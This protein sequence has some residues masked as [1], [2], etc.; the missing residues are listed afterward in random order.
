MDEIRAQGLKA[1][2]ERCRL[3][4]IRC[5]G[6]TNARGFPSKAQL[7]SWI[8]Q[9]V[10]GN[11]P[12]PQPLAVRTGLEAENFRRVAFCNA[13][14]P[15]LAGNREYVDS[16]NQCVEVVDG[17]QQAASFFCEAQYASASLFQFADLIG[18]RFPPWF[19][20]RSRLVR[21][22]MEVH[23]AFRTRDPIAT[24]KCW[25]I[26]KQSTHAF[27]PSSM[28][29]RV[30]LWFYFEVQLLEIKV[31]RSCAKLFEVCPVPEVTG[32]CVSLPVCILGLIIAPNL[33]TGWQMLVGVAQFFCSQVSTQILRDIPCLIKNSASVSLDF[34]IEGDLKRRFNQPHGP[35]WW[36]SLAQTENSRQW[37]ES[38]LRSEGLLL[39]SEETM[40][41]IRYGLKG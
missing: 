20:E 10:T 24:D 32:P 37:M 2:T 36:K 23:D 28:E 35:S 17:L 18:T 27:R 34:Y 22:L 30:L 9:Q 5:S 39:E 6:E 41:A 12:Q 3:E 40:S 21:F 1:F 13:N 29:A 31:L 7:E 15:N 14:W 26:T 4:Q 16:L 19:Q 8:Q 33:L 25:D 11:D 38:V